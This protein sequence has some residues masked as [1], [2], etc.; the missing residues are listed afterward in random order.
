MDFIQFE[1]IHESQQNETINFSDDEKADQDENFIDDS[2][3][4]M[5]DV[6]FYRKFDPENIDHHNKFPN[7]TGDPRV[8]VHEDD[9]MFFGTE[10][11]QPELYAPENSENVEFNKFVGFEKSVKKLKETLQ[12][13]DNTDNP[14]F[15]SIVFGLMFK[16]TKGKVLEKKIKQT[17]SLER[18][19]MKGY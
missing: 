7:Q 11:Q 8:A 6:S 5:E 17:M 15:D 3:Q 14:F 1:A 9:E 19:F 16:I 10:D 13:F 12:N 2:E 18:I 4:P